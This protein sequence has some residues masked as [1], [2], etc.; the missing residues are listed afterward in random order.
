MSSINTERSAWF[1]AAV[2]NIFIQIWAK[3]V[4]HWFSIALLQHCQ[5]HGQVFKKGS[6]LMQQRYCLILLHTV[7]FVKTWFLHCPQCNLT[8]FT[9]LYILGCI[10]LVAANLAL[11]SDFTWV[12]LSVLQL[13]QKG[14]KHNFRGKWSLIDLLNNYRSWSWAETGCMV[15]Y[16]VEEKW[17]IAR[18]CGWGE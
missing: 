18:Q 11:S 17:R 1:K 8:W 4:L 2:I 5:T 14:T 6:K 13:I 3:R 15:P 10:I 16:M 9:Q 12:S 7:F